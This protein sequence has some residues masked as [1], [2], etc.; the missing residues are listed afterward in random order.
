MSNWPADDGPALEAYYGTHELGPDGLP[1]PAW[2]RA[3]L[4]TLDLPYSMVPS[5]L[6]HKSIRRI[7]CHRLVAESLLRV[8][9]RILAHYGTEQRLRKSRMHMYG[10]AYNY[11]QIAGSKRL[12]A[13]AYGAAIDLDPEGNPLGVPWRADSPMMPEA[14]VAIFEAEG[15]KWGGRFQSR[16]DC[17]HFQAT[18]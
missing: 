7:R 8:F 12:S 3:N 4:T 9:E 14:V 17:M 18:I 1:T 2:L 15:W 5:W 11:R 16:A 6:L 10:G 13:H